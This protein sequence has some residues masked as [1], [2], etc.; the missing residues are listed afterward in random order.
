MTIA[1]KD[2]PVI[3][4]LPGLYGSGPDHWQSAWQRE[5]PHAQW[6]SQ[7]DWSA[8]ERDA[9]VAAL[10]RAVGASSGSILLVA[11]SLG[12]TTV[13]HWAQRCQSEQL[14]R[15]RGALLVAVP[16]VERADAP[17]AV[18]SF[19]PLP[20]APLPFPSMV[21][22]S[23]DDPWCRLARA[24][25]WADAWGATWQP[26]GAQ[27]HINAESGLGVWRQGQTWLRQLIDLTAC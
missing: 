18:R 6:V 7:Q 9:W 4:L 26:C 20:S 13:V 11:H 12:C 15:I 19:A 8:P 14:S 16:D 3:L 1:A 22:A 17:A 2:K 10:N 24:R 23:S 25:H 21:V 27:G 5:L